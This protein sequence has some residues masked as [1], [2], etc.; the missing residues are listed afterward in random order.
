MANE[1][2][3]PAGL[4]L[5]ATPLGACGIAWDGR[6]V[7]LGLHL[8]EASVAATRRRLMRRYPGLPE[9]C[10]PD[11]V[12]RV[13]DAIGRL[14]AGER[15]DLAAAPLALETVPPFNRRV[16]EVARTIPPGRTVTYGEI[17]G[18]LGD[19]SLARAVGQALG[20]NP[21]PIVVPCHR[22]VAAGG[23]NGGFSASGG[24]RTKLRLLALEGA[25][26]NALL[27]LFG[28]E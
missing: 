12:Q 20:A 28:D 8:P 7:I 27:P 10:P 25:T 24:V 1:R 21:F 4:A 16:Y 26:A 3:A 2:S 15:V 14:L 23:L 22:V 17:A 13:V 5:F 11:G 6:G 18:R 9:A 19:R